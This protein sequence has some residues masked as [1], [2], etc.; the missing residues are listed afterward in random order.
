[1]LERGDNKLI[2]LKENEVKQKNNS[3]LPQC[4]VHIH[5]CNHK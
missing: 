3:I 2:I 5:N 1:M 4:N